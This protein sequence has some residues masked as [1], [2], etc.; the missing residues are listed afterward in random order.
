MPSLNLLSIDPVSNVL[1]S[2]CLL[3]QHH[4][5][6]FPRA[7]SFSFNEGTQHLIVCHLF[8]VAVL[9]CVHYPRRQGIALG[10]GVKQSPLT[11]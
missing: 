5:L 3:R 2:N 1:Q 9:T 11:V 6:N 7:Q 8:S 4:D 10:I